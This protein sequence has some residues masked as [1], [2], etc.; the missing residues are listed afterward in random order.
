MLSSAVTQLCRQCRQQL[1][2][3]PVRCSHAIVSRP[4]QSDVELR[5][6]LLNTPVRFAGHSHWQNVK[7][8]KTEKDM[9][10]QK[11]IN[12]ILHRIRGA[13]RGLCCI[14]LNYVLNVFLAFILARNQVLL[15]TLHT[16]SLFSTRCIR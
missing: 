10:R 4:L 3:L 16:M 6:W 13:V 15:R 2:I 12:V 7:K 1:I 9:E 14:C 11:L 8:I 5:S